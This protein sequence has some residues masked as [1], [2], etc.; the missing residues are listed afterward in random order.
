MLE[1]ASTAF[2]AGVTLAVFCSV[3]DLWRL[4]I[5]FIREGLF[6]VSLIW[7]HRDF[8]SAS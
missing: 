5:R 3:V 8:Q 1:L 4:E 6:V 2:E 7:R